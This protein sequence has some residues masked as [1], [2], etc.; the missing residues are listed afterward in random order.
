M[1]VKSYKKDIVFPVAKTLKDNT[2][3]CLKLAKAL[4]QQPILFENNTLIYSNASQY[5]EA[6]KVCDKFFSP[7]EKQRNILVL[8]TVCEIHNQPK[9]QGTHEIS[10]KVHEFIIYSNSISNININFSSIFS[11][12]LINDNKFP[13]ESPH[14]LSR[15]FR[16]S[17][18]IR[19]FIALKTTSQHIK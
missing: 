15:M 2:N 3:R 14:F 5:S 19:L 10:C 9:S 13:K 17:L 11:I 12:F 4:P 18:G 1:P 7:V 6:I 16:N 8:L